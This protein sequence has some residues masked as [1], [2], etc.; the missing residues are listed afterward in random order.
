MS[1]FR[2]LLVA[3]MVG[4]VSITSI[5]GL[6]HGWN[7]MPIFFRDI[8]SLTW[9]GMFNFDL[10]CFL[11]LSALWL[12]WRHQF[13]PC[14]LLLGLIGFFGGTM[15]LAPYLLIVSFSAKG[16]M[17]EILLGKTRTNNN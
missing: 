13:S 6:K 14:G 7:F 10:M 9:P 16:D 12:A 2:L 5:V 3:M 11:L 8:A 15:F 1:A 17:A 4:I